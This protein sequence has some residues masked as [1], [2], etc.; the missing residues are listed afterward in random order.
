MDAR[1]AADALVY[2]T[3]K[4]LKE[5]KDRLDAG[6]VTKLEAGVESLKGALKGTSS[7]EIKA[8]SERLNAIWHEAA[9][10]MYQ[11]AGSAGS[12]P[13]GESAEAQSGAEKGPDGAADAEYEVID[14]D[15]NQK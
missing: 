15:A 14:E 8:A 5:Y 12:A 1:N 4:N 9:Q 6:D 3:E 2:Q 13:Q 7:D 10:R 11:Q